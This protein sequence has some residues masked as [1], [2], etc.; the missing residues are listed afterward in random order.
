MVVDGHFVSEHEI[1]VCAVRH[2]HDVHVA[3]FRSALSPV[4]VRENVVPANFLSRFDLSP[5]GDTPVKE[6]VVSRH[7]LTTRGRLHVLQERGEPSNNLAR[8]ERTGDANEFLEREPGFLRATSPR[9]VPD[10]IGGE[11]AL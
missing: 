9:I 11:L 3:E 5:D 7:A 8:A 10:L 1:F 4:C 2:G 6:R